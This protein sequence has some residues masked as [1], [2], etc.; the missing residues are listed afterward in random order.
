MQNVVTEPAGP[1]L[2]VEY[3]TKSIILKDGTVVKVQ[4]W[5]TCN[6]FY[7]KS[8][9]TNPWKIAGSERYKSITTA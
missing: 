6:Y 8:S 1:T 3:Q 4:I 2:G 9:Q 7:Q 5:D